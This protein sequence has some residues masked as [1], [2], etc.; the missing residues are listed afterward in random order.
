LE[1]VINARIFVW[2][3]PVTNSTAQNVI[4]RRITKHFSSPKTRSEKVPL[5][6]ALAKLT[7]PQATSWMKK[8]KLTS[9]ATSVSLHVLLVKRL[10]ITASAVT[11]K[12]TSITHTMAI[13]MK[14]VQRLLLQIF[15]ISSVWVAHRTAISAV[16]LEKATVT[17][18]PTHGC[19]KR[20]SAEKNVNRV[21]TMLTVQ[22]P[23]VSTKPS[24]HGSDRSS[25]TSQSSL[26]SQF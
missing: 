5:I 18:V 22:E 10:K 24:S 15:P 12:I 19:S 4:P 16:L 25:L 26:S 8:T 17:S 14:S 23:C 2:T 13:A 11:E 6:V 20:A 21:V 3:A 1:I 9:D 7:A